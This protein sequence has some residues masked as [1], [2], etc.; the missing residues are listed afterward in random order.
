MSMNNENAS[1][2]SVANPMVDMTINPD[3]SINTHSISPHDGTGHAS[4]TMQNHEM[5][6]N[7]TDQKGILYDEQTEVETVRY[8]K[9]IE[10]VNVCEK[11]WNMKNYFS[12]P[13]RIASR[14]WATTATAG[15]VLATFPLP[16]FIKK[17]DRWTSLLNR[18]VYFR[19][20][21]VF[22]LELNGTAFHSGKLVMINLPNASGVAT[23]NT[24]VDLRTIPGLPHVTIQP[25]FNTVVELET[26][27]LSTSEYL[28]TDG[29]LT[30]AAEFT[31]EQ[32][33]SNL[34]VV[35]FN[36]L[37]V[38]TGASTAL[39]F[40][41]YAYLK[42]VELFIPKML[43]GSAQGLFNYTNITNQIQ[44]M[45]NSN[46]PQ[47]VTGDEYDIELGLH[48]LDLPIDT[49][50]PQSVARTS[51][52]SNHN[53][54]GFPSMKRLS[55]F[56]ADQSIASKWN[57]ETPYDEMGCD[58]FTSRWNYVKT[59]EF[60]T[61]QT[62]GK[63]LGDLTPIGPCVTS[64]GHLGFLSQFFKYW[65]GDMEF[66]VEVVGTQYHTAK[67]FCGVSYGPQGLQNFTTTG[68]DPTTTYGKVI[69]IN[70]AKTCFEINV[71]F[72]YPLPWVSVA[73]YPYAN[74]KA[75]ALVT[76]A[77]VVPTISGSN[78]PFTQP[79][80]SIGTF[81]IMVL[82]PLVVPAGMATS[83]DIN[84]YVR[85]GKNFVFHTTG[86]PRG[87]WFSIA[88]AG[89]VI[90]NCPDNAMPTVRS[91][92][93]ERIRSTKDMLKRFTFWGSSSLS[94]LNEL[95]NTG[96]DYS[97]VGSACYI[98]LSTVHATAS[99]FM[100]FNSAYRAMTGDLRL[101]IIA[102][103]SDS[104]QEMMHV[105]YVPPI[106]TQYPMDTFHPGYAYLSQILLAYVLRTTHAPTSEN[107]M[108]RQ[109]L[110]Q[111][112][113]LEAFDLSVNG[114]G[115]AAFG[116]PKLP[117]TEAESTPPNLLTSEL[118]T[119]SAPILELEI[120]YTET[121]R[122]TLTPGYVRKAATGNLLTKPPKQYNPWGYL[123]LWCPGNTKTSPIAPVHANV[124]VAAGD[125][126]RYG[127]WSSPLR[128]NPI[129][130]TRSFGKSFTVGTPSWE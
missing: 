62:F 45:E 5:H 99:Q 84:I 11:P 98:D 19:C 16:Y 97:Q 53:V 108:F 130:T 101:K 88:Q 39:N 56:P 23:L 40:T 81:F 73:S 68:I 2:M 122:F 107:L 32:T 57:F 9:T 113:D 60:P 72:Q 33:F 49:N 51:S 37:R 102:S 96:I 129:V 41:L 35:V 24:I 22:R 3:V 27:W 104:H 66:C 17:F 42:D 44:N 55:Y 21:P 89:E 115:S 95:F 1:L 74:A 71:P 50:A 103:F 85:P 67:I 110:A 114:A 77:V 111:V 7:T 25:A 15:T 54:K 29:E 125:N 46:L 31:S 6:V 105:I 78:Y 18:Y 30:T 52:S 112:N 93:N 86:T 76:P 14:S 69:E 4:Q 34:N 58:Y 116:Q 75:S 128:T 28:T 65:R 10:G 26:Q 126:F 43:T 117:L 100:P 12:V 83:I 91:N 118:L 13:V 80:G 64:A 36:P 127:Q 47:Q 119:H 82:N 8:P 94:P 92:L 106:Y 38:G 109:V 70:K 59:V 124:Y 20:R 123:I 61:T 87:N 120:P 48:G 79:N 90:G 63:I 121:A